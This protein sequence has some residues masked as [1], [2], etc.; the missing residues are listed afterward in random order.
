MR[1]FFVGGF[2]IA[3]GY[4]FTGK[5]RNPNVEIRTGTVRPNRRSSEIQNI[6]S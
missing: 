6:E 1:R 3:I 2:L 4:L 5:I